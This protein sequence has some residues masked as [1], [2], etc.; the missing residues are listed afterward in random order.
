V[1]SR[2]IGIA[3][4]ESTVFKTKMFVRL[5]FNQDVG[6]LSKN[7]GVPLAFPSKASNNRGNAVE[8]SFADGRMLPTLCWS[9]QTSSSNARL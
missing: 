2:I 9:L 1:W 4:N 7:G 3:A 6:V 5:K 8:D